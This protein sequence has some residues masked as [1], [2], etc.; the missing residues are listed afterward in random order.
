MHKIQGSGS[1]NSHITVANPRLDYSVGIL[2]Q[3]NA[4]SLYILVF[5]TWL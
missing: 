5:V 4:A 3:F 2:G 1:Q